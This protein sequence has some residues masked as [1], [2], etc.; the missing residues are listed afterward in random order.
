MTLKDIINSKHIK[1]LFKLI[2][3]SVLYDS[4]ITRIAALIKRLLQVLYI[5]NYTLFRLV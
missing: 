5:I 2:Q 4:N 1:E 3:D